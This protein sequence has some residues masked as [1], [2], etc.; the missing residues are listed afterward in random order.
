MKRVKTYEIL[1]KIKDKL[2]WNKVL[3]YGEESYLTQQFLKKVSTIREVEKF[4]A[5]EELGSFLNFT[6][7]SLFGNSPLPVLL[8]VE[9]LTELLRK[10]ADKE[11]FI[12]FLKSLDSFILVS[13]EEIDYRKLKTEVFSAIL[14][15]VDVV[16]HSENYPQEKILSLVAKKFHSEGRKVSKE[17]VKLI[18]EIVGTDLRELR[19]ETEKL[20]LYPGEL[21][22]EV[23][24][25]LLFSSGKANVFE[26]IF[27]LVEGNRKEYLNQLEELLRKGADPLSLI[28]L[29]QTQLRQLLS[30]ATG[31]R[32]RLPPETIKKLRALLKGKSYTE[33]LLL[34]KK[35]HEKEFAVKRGILNGEEALKSLAFET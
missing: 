10:K 2:P 35:L 23:V 31:D 33:L 22:P 3:I 5:D 34:L 17:I 24:K 6:G 16:I 19:S 29:L 21:T 12:K 27:P 30:M 20:L 1:K 18:V 13:Y 25:L 4:H 26:L 15:I 7:T 11:R 8:G 28:A 9:K 14:E 32:V